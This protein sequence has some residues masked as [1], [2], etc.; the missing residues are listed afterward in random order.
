M[1]AGGQAAQ[2]PA[3]HCGCDDDD[4]ERQPEC[5]ER[6]KGGDRERDERRVSERAAGDA[7][8]GLGDDGEHGRRQAGEQGGDQRGVAGADVEGR[9]GEQRE[10]PGQHEQGAGDQAAADPVEQPA[11]VD[12]QLLGLGP[13]Q[14]GAVGQGVQEPALANPAPLVDQRALHDGDLTGR[15]TEGLQ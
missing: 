15:A 2:R 11:D 1:V 4:G 13:G 6:E 9:Q 14:Q 12:G 7:N 8:D 5:G 10:H 3:D